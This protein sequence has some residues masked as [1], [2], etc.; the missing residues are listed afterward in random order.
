MSKRIL[1]LN[2]ISS[3]SNDDYLVVDGSSGTRKITPENIVGN[4]AVA[5]TLADHISSASDAIDEMQT[6]I[7]TLQGEI[8]NIPVVRF[9]DPN[10][11]G[12][13]VISLG[14]D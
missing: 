1:D 13:I 4:S 7:G 2:T 5:Q 8:E 9:T 11:D 6:T 14:G 12:N 10:S 3:A